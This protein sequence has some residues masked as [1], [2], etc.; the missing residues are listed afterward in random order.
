MTKKEIREYIRSKKRALQSDERKVF[1]SRILGKLFRSDFYR[2][3]TTIY[4]YVSYN[5]EVDTTTLIKQALKDKK[6]IAVPKVIGE[7]IEFF[8]I[9]SLDELQ[10]GYQH[11][12]EPIT[13][14]V[15]LLKEEVSPLVI[16][17]GL[18]FDVKGNRIGYGGGFYDRYLTKNTES[19]A[20]TCALGYE[21]QL[22]DEIETEQFD[23]KINHIITPDKQINCG[24]EKKG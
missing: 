21:F 24:F 1:S 10:E 15:A 11:I 19:N 7:E 5:Q 4:T 17:P 12:F 16:M 3:A 6:R 18:A 14:E 20:I 13:N 9:T 23:V 8:Y 2:K 22:F